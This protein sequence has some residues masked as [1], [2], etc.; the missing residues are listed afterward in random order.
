MHPPSPEGTGRTPECGQAAGVYRDTI[1]QRKRL[2]KQP[3]FAKLRDSVSF[4]YPGFF[5]FGSDKWD[6]S[7]EDLESEGTD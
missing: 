4:R 7:Q 3:V 2:W 5:G 6:L 1:R